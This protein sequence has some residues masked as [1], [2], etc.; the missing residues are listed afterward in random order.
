VRNGVPSVSM[1]VFNDY[2]DELTNLCDQ[3]PRDDKETEGQF[4]ALLVSATRV[5]GERVSDKLDLP[6]TFVPFR[7]AI[8]NMSSVPDVAPNS[9][10]DSKGG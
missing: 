8:M 4:A 2:V 10:T 5:L 6:R 7:N 1:E 9:T 3:L